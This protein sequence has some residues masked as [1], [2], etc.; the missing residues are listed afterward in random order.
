MCGL[1]PPDYTDSLRVFQQQ[2]PPF[3]PE[4]RTPKKYGPVFTIDHI[5]HNHYTNIKTWV[6]RINK[7]IVS[8]TELMAGVK[9]PPKTVQLFQ[10]T[11]W[12]MGHKVPTSTNSLVELM[13]MVERWRQRTDY[14]PVCVVSP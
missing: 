11:C 2:F 4:G 13:N 3:W 12:P 9:A 6:F 14:G 10:L 8:L 7:K 1:S 5:S